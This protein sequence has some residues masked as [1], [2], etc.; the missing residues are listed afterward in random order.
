MLK[1]K[2]DFCCKFDCGAKPLIESGGLMPQGFKCSWKYPRIA[3]PR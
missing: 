2:S 1:V 3:F